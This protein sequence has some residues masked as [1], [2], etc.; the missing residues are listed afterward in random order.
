MD[1]VQGDGV[2]VV[3]GAWDRGRVVREVVVELGLDGEPVVAF[4]PVC[5]V[6]VDQGRGRSVLPVGPVLEC[7]LRTEEVELEKRLV[8]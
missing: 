1:E 6:L 7:D 4:G 8:D 5:L 2:G 3:A